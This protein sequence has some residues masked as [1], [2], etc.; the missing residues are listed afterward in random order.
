MAN[1]VDNRT[2]NAD[3][4]IGQEELDNL[5]KLKILH[6]RDSKKKMSKTDMIEKLEKL[7]PE[8]RIKVIEK[9]KKLESDKKIEKEKR[10]RIYGVKID[11]CEHMK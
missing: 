8:E 2:D 3:I 9:L 11:P 6:R 4:A 10:E 7:D 1:K 5:E